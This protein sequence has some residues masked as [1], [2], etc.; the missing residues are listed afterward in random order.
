MYAM[1]APNVEVI[2]TEAPA[3]GTQMRSIW[4]SG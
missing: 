3:K 1:E 2:G 4:V